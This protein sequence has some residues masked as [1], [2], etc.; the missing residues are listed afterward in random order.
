[1]TTRLSLAAALCA[2]IAAFVGTLTPIAHAITTRFCPASGSERMPPARCRHQPIGGPWSPVGFPGYNQSCADQ[3]L[4]LVRDRF[5]HLRLVKL[6]CGGGT[7]TTMVAG[8]PWSSAWAFSAGSRL[9]E[10]KAFLQE[11]RGEIAFVAAATT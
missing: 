3:L 10:A 1:M 5:E 11:H 8:S 2:V 9:G 6:G 7:I 4:K